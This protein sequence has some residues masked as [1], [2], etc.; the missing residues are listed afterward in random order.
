MKQ[1]IIAL[2]S[3]VLFTGCSASSGNSPV[4]KEG[5]TTALSQTAPGTAASKTDAPKTDAAATSPVVVKPEIGKTMVYEKFELTINSIKKA[6]G[7]D[8]QNGVLID[9]TFKNLDEES[10][11]PVWGTSLRLFQDGVECQQAFYTSSNDDVAKRLTNATTDIKKG[12]PISCLT[13]FE[14]ESDSPLTIQIEPFFNF[15]KDQEIKFTADYPTS[16]FKASEMSAHAKL[17]DNEQAIS[18]EIKELQVGQVIELT[19]F[20]M[21]IHG[22]Y[23]GKDYEGKN[24]VML[25]YTMKNK[26]DRAADPMWNNTVSLYQNGVELENGVYSTQNSVIDSAMRGTMRMVMPGATVQVLEFYKTPGTKEL[27]INIKSL[28]GS[29][30]ETIKFKTAYPQEKINTK[31]LSARLTED[32]KK[33][34]AE[35]KPLL[36]QAEDVSLIGQTLELDSSDVT[37]TEVKSTSMSNGKKGLIVYYTYK[38][39]MDENKMPAIQISVKAYQDGIEID[40]SYF[41]GNDKYD[42][43][44]GNTSKEIQP[45]A[46]VDCAEAFEYA[47]DSLVILEISEGFDLNSPEPKM[48]VIKP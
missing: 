16:D 7:Y 26:Q 41:V 31:T 42:K 14:T 13:F 27:E 18:G 3:L 24:G 43:L 10:V 9:Y 12:V 44:N 29:S 32:Y 37:I 6:K 5:T 39:K 30:D 17:G 25:D 34:S 15:D 4:V 2:L 40:S 22:I 47:S 23:T 20:D 11:R 1:A 46:S 28:W 33:Y 19:D 21:V 38:N 48:L 45:G 35:V 8:K 36:P